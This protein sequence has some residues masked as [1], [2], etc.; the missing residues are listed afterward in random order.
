MQYAYL[1]LPRPD[2]LRMIPALQDSPGNRV[3][4][5]GCAY[6]ST[7]AV[8][9]QQGWEVHGVD[10]VP[11]AIDI[12]R[13]RIASATL[14]KPGEPLPWPEASF[15]G[16]L[17]A[18][19]VEHIPQAATVLAQWARLVKPGGW[20]VISVPNM[21]QVAVLWEFIFKG[22]W[23]ERDTGIFDRTHLQV[24]SKKRLARWCAA[25]D[26]RI[27]KWFELYG[28]NTHRRSK[29]FRACDWLTL[30]LFHKWWVYQL[31]VRCR[32]GQ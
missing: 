11:Q 3:L 4:S 18:D 26:L 17:L 12:A 28:P 31:Q 8:L 7:E 5:V 25:A 15:D 10:I 27:E 19:V 2:I 24:M 13:T 9:A 6:A 29:I 21:R 16:L 1:D 22:D 20:I 30:R 14:L 32:R 23:P